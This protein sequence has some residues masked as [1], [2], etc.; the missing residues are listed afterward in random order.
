MAS[1]AAG[2]EILRTRSSTAKQKA[3]SANT[4]KP[5]SAAKRERCVSGA[6]RQRKG[7][8]QVSM[9]SRSTDTPSNRPTSA[10]LFCAVESVMRVARRTMDTAAAYRHSPASS[11]NRAFSAV[12]RIACGDAP[13]SAA[14]TTSIRKSSAAVEI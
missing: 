10:M 4:P 11:T 12:R 1:S 3:P 6:R 8:S 7:Y 13:S 5:A 9:I 14:L 2:S